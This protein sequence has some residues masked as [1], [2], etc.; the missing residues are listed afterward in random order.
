MLI[1]QGLDLE[2][3]DLQLRTPLHHASSISD[4]RLAVD[5]FPKNE[6]KQ[7]ITIDFLF[8]RIIEMLLSNKANVEAYDKDGI[9]PIDLAIS[10]NNEAAVLQMLKKGAKLGPTTWTTAKGKPR[11]T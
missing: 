7:S 5:F 4:S 2:S 1:K 9:R 3:C 10:Y 11:L 8:H 6:T